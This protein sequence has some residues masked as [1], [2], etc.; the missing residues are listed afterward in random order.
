MNY[1]DDIRIDEENLDLEWLEQPNLMIKYTKNAA[2]AR[3]NLD[4]AKQTLDIV[5]AEVDSAIRKDPEHYGL[6]KVT[7]AAVASTLLIQEEYK[8][9]FEN[10][11]SAKYEADMAQGAVTAFSQRKDALEN[12]VRLFGLNY[13]S[14][15]RMT[16]DLHEKRMERMKNIDSGISSKFK[17]NIKEQ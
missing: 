2:E 12:L 8:I 11:L 14:G 5:K 4:N 1:E 13:F 17:R 7:D 6:I 16:K 10:Y 3:M 9:A 15:P